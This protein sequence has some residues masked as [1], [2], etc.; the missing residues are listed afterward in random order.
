MKALGQTGER[1]SAIGLGTQQMSNDAWWGPADEKESIQTVH[2]AI[3]SGINLIDTAPIYGF[4]HCEELVGKALLGGKRNRVLVSTKCGLWWKSRQQNF[5]F[6]LDRK[7]VYK[8]L[9]PDIIRQEIEWSLK[10]L[11]TD[12]ID[13]YHVHHYDGQTSVESIAYTLGQLQKEGKLRFI[14]VSNISLDECR[15]YKKYCNV[16]ANQ[17]KY[18]VLDGLMPEEIQQDY[19]ALQI[20]VI[21]YSP[22]EQG[23]LTGALTEDSK[24]SETDYRNNNPWFSSEN[25]RRVIGLLESWKNFAMKYQCSLAQLVL[26]YTIGLPYI[27][28]ALCGARNPFHIQQDA[29]SMNIHI[30]DNDRKSMQ[31][32]IECLLNRKV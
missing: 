28:S 21:A 9:K 7:K 13:I 14:A 8:S 27:T 3:D 19:H 5:A 12:Y 25:R 26:A 30:L 16:V 10:R 20:A 6:V 29:D 31:R 22:L 17:I 32:D 4:G 1:V 18:S 24:L 23:L 15:T 2:A 11:K